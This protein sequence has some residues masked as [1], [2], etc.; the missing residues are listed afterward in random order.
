L[1]A[2]PDDAV[3]PGVTIAVQTLPEPS[4]NTFHLV[5]VSNTIS[6]N[7]F[8][9]QLIGEDTTEMLEELMEIMQ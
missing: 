6:P 2:T 3:G 9:L 4:S 7:S 8:S 5:R 1:T